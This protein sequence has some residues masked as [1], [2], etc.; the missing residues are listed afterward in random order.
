VRRGRVQRRRR[1]RC[2]RRH[3]VLWEYLHVQTSSSGAGYGEWI[4][5]V[6]VAVM[7]AIQDSIAGSCC[8]LGVATNVAR[9]QCFEF[10]RS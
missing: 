6:D 2:R 9:L 10:I 4:A 3:R 1:R 7:K 8:V 5:A